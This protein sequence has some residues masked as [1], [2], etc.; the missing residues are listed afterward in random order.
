M[1]SAAHNFLERVEPE[2]DF[3]VLAIFQSPEIAEIVETGQVEG[4]ILFDEI[5]SSLKSFD[6][7]PEQVEEIVGIIVN[8]LE[9]EVRRPEALAEETETPASSKNTDPETTDTLRLF[10]QRAAKIDL[11]TPAQ[12]VQIAKRMEQGDSSAKNEMVEANLR[13]VVSIA[14]RYTGHGVELV[15]LIQDGI[16]G[17]IRATEKFDWRQGFKFSTYATWWIRQSVERAI[18]DKARTIRFPVHVG[19]KIRKINKATNRLHGELGREP[20][21][22]EIAQEVD[23]TEAEIEKLLAMAKPLISLDKPIVEG[24]QD[25]FIELVADDKEE[26]VEDGVNR[27]WRQQALETALAQLPED[28]RRILALRYGLEGSAPHKAAEVARL[29]KTN[30]E[31]L[32][33]VEHK[34]L[35]ELAK[36]PDLKAGVT[37]PDFQTGEDFL[38]GDKIDYTDLLKAK[39]WPVREDLS[40]KGSVIVGYILQGM[41]R[42]QISKE[43]GQSFNTIRADSFVMYKALG[44][45]SWEALVAEVLEKY[46]DSIVEEE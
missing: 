45:K 27:N 1:E 17:L 20:V 42:A 3:D 7:Q 35:D 11:L 38:P 4:F 33:L 43:L 30:P 16:P 12:E 39:D 25:S 40:E 6:L 23:L 9:V 31:R 18:A 46:S 2:P 21:I 13:L 5:A 19:E 44:V 37:D 22:S 10:L 26:T 8:E 41:D 29:L 34:I 32:R 24:E 36:D 14:K 15:D 28:E